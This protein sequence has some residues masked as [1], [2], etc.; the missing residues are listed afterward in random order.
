MSGFDLKPQ[1]TM[2][3]PEDDKLMAQ[4][5]QQA[6]GQSGQGLQSGANKGPQK[7]L[8]TPVANL[9]NQ[10]IGSDH[11]Y[12]VEL[13]KIVDPSAGEA[14][15]MALLVD[16]AEIMTATHEFVPQFPIH[17]GEEARTF[18]VRYAPKTRGHSST[19][20]AFTACFQ[21]GYT[22]N[23]K[24]PVS[25]DARDL[26]DARNGAADHSPGLDVDVESA[27]TPTKE[28]TNRPVSLGF[29]DG[30]QHLQSSISQVFAEAHDG[31]DQVEIAERGFKQAPPPVSIWV[32]LA[33]IAIEVALSRISEQL[34]HMAGEGVEKVL[35]KARAEKHLHAIEHFSG[36][37]EKLV[38]S[39][40]KETKITE[41]DAEH[42][43]SNEAARSTDDSSLHANPTYRKSHSP[44]TMKEPLTALPFFEAQKT[45]LNRASSSAAGKLSAQTI[46]LAETLGPDSP[47]V[48]EA[49]HDASRAVEGRFAEM[50]ELQVD[51]TT[52]QWMNAL[53]RSDLGVSSGPN[54][55]V[56]TTMLADVRNNMYG[57][58]GRSARGLLEIELKSTHGVFSISRVKLN[59][60][61]RETAERVLEMDLQKE[62]IPIAI[63][64][65]DGSRTITVD[66]VGRVRSLTTF[67]DRAR[68]K[69]E[70]LDIEETPHQ[71]AQDDRDLEQLVEGVLSEPLKNQGVTE[72]ETDEASKE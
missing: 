61:T 5:P 8:S 25:A 11:T 54:D 53:V 30:Q 48:N 52:V 6:R 36:G 63:R 67:P 12:H 34:G 44:A 43:R 21:D 18:D 33:Q 14:R 39:S 69:L 4:K 64:L 9:G 35:G 1:P 37:I 60:V 40:V 41:L 20:L 13:P 58:G 56:P 2:L 28:E 16:S 70:E 15:A 24:V 23:V 46:A 65:F 72:I 50:K 7:R 32:H 17:F 31:V 10:L 55:P 71:E 22:E 47:A 42:S 3:A 45:A 27:R 66:E 62:R 68:S 49:L 59:G 51:A 57:D 26:H 38:E 29:L 19:K